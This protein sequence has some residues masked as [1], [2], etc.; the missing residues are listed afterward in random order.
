MI[1]TGLIATPIASG[2]MSP[3]AFPI[4]FDL[5]REHDREHHPDRV[6]SSCVERGDAHFTRS[7]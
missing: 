5:S 3:I 6:M 1:G 2:R 4:G 7:A